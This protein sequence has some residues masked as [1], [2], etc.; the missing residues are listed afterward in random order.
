M[1]PQIPAQVVFASAEQVTRVAIQVKLVILDLVSVELLL[2]V[3]DKQL[4]HIV[5]PL[6]TFANAHQL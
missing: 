6:T 2:L 5:M 4:D 1:V 3:W